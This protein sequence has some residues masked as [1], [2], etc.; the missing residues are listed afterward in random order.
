MA[1]IAY[2]L[3]LGAFFVLA[4][5]YVLACDRIV[6]SDEDALADGPTIVD[7]TQDEGPR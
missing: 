1:D 3:V 6:G 2:L 5:L 7:T 4:G